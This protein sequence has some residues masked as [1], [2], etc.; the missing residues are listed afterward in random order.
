MPRRSA[1]SGTRPMLGVSKRMPGALR[2]MPRRSARLNTRR[3]LGLRDHMPGRSTS[4]DSRHMPRVLKIMP[5]VLAHMPG[6]SADSNARPMPR[7]MAL[8]RDRATCPAQPGI[9]A[10]RFARKIVGFWQA[11]PSALA[12]AECQAV[13]RRPIPYH[14]P[15][16]T[17][18][19]C[20]PRPQRMV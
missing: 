14:S 6:R 8:G 11:S 18:G 17:L 3:M 10:D 15:N 16:H 2:N 12:A 1:I 9:A 5:G 13:G 7:H 20:N 19:D 4:S